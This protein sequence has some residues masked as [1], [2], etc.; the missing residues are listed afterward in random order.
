M[1]IQ[2]ENIRALDAPGKAQKKA[3]SKIK[4]LTSKLF[5]ILVITSISMMYIE[6]VSAIKLTKIGSTDQAIFG[7]TITYGYEIKNDDGVDLHDVV[8]HDDRLGDI[9]IGN[10]SNGKNWD[11]TINHKIC[12]CDYP[13]PL[14]NIGSSL[15]SVGSRVNLYSNSC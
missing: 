2:L 8:L 9:A 5:I 7:D 15:F 3:K 13:G 14:N 11:E 12:E 1:D 4:G 6:N 10:L